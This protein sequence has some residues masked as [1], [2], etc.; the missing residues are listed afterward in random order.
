MTK[1]FLKSTASQL[2]QIGPFL[3]DDD[4]ITPKTGLTIANTDIQFLKNDGTS[5]VNKNS[6]GATEIANGWYY[7]TL[8]ATDTN[9]EGSLIMRCKIDD[10]LLVW[11]E[12]EV[13]DPASALYGV[14][15][16][17]WKGSAAPAMTGDAYARLGAPAGA[18]VSADIAAL[19]TDAD[20][21]AAC[22]TSI[23][24]AGLATASALATVAG[25]LDTE[26]A[27]ILAD[28][29]ELQ[30]DL[31]NGGRLDL[32]I[33]GIKAKTD[34]IATAP[35]AAAVADA[36]WDEVLSGHTTSG[37]AGNALSTASSG[38]VDPAV[39]ADAIWDE[40][41]SGHTSAGSAGAFLALLNSYL[42]ATVSSRLAT[43]G[44][45]APPTAAAVRQEIDSNSTQL[46]AIVLDTGTTL[47]TK[48]NTIDSILDN[49]HDTDLPAVKTDTAAIATVVDLIP[50]LAEIEASTVLAKA[51]GLITVDQI[52]DE[53]V[54][55]TLTHRQAMRIMLAA[56][57][58]KA[59]GGGTTAIAYRDIADTKD[60]ISATVD[61]DG[62]RTAITRDGT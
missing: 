54:E 23:S 40:I 11:R 39:L 55:G 14:N 15:V 19:P 6:G 8:D 5:F 20:V 58:G 32:L 62:N 33:D 57:A 22:D 42:D 61:T 46:A 50:T 34:T 12:W 31:T 24:D 49:I 16:V 56:L 17:N 47:D 21:N 59:T 10:C 2:I 53:V 29:N 48:I 9:T 28:T 26:V 44:Y 25:Y 37:T 60:R 4:G 27:A 52:H 36:V 43:S 38:G 45:T 41:M 1:R 51:A 7:I 18:S 30:T 3:D 35:T 13:I